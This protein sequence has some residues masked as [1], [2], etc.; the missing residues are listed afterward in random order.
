M[1]RDRVVALQLEGTQD[2]A[3]YRH[4]LLAQCNALHQAMPFLFEPIAAVFEASLTSESDDLAEH[5]SRASS[6]APSTA[7]S[8]SRPG[9][10]PT[11]CPSSRRYFGTRA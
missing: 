3:L 9:A 8:P 10:V 5:P 4:L 2:E 11:P 7:S 6:V 1:N